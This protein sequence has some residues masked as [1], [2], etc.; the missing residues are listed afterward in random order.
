MCDACRERH[1]A[2][3]DG[4]RG[5]RRRRAIS[6]D[7]EMSNAV[8]RFPTSIGSAPAIGILMLLLIVPSLTPAISQQ[9]AQHPDRQQAEDAANQRLRSALAAYKAQ[10]YAAAQREL[11]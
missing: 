9:S 6:A 2:M 3:V 5:E 4:D 7:V 1:H 11:A 10:R 8:R